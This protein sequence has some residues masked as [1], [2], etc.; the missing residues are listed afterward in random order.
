MVAQQKKKPRCKAIAG[1]T[2]RQCKKHGW[3]GG[4]Y[5]WA[6]YPKKEF[7][8]SI[9]V[10]ALVSCSP[11]IYDLLTT[12]QS[13]QRLADLE[14]IER[15][16]EEGR[17]ARDTE[18]A[19]HYQTEINRYYT[20]FAI[21]LHWSLPLGDLHDEAVDGVFR[22]NR[23]LGKGINLAALDLELI[24]H[25]FQS[26][27]FTEPMLNYNHTTEFQPTGFN[28]LLGNLSRFHSDVGKHL[29]KYGATATPSLSSRMDYARAFAK[30]EVESLRLSLRVTGMISPQAAQGLGE[31]ML[32]LR[33]DLDWIVETYGRGVYPAYVG[34][35]LKSHPTEGSL[36]VQWEFGEY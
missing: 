2:N 16:A 27:D 12:S 17:R 33:K 19:H 11:T 26:Y 34:Q 29:E 7:I 13:E 30:S 35:V 6:H 32:L 23:D 4:A 5:C 24:Q 36:A 28:H 15:R 8:L 31:F 25:I 3:R 21:F 9:V 14:A 1:Q 20:Q 10:T 18:L 22:Y